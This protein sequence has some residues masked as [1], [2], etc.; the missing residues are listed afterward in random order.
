MQLVEDGTG[1][2][3]RAPK[4]LFG[5]IMH[6]EVGAQHATYRMAAERQNRINQNHLLLS[7]TLHTTLKSDL[8]IMSVEIGRTSKVRQLREEAVGH[9]EGLLTDKLEE[10][11]ILQEQLAL[12]SKHHVRDIQ[13]I[14]PY[15][16]VGNYT[17]PVHNDKMEG[18]GTMKYDDGRVYAG[19]YRGTV[20]ISYIQS[21]LH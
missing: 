7:H 2:V 1:T 5:S 14:D 16:D 11:A 10:V 21:T 3:D 8:I 17:G 19:E 4:Y 13:M 6:V 9:L 18:N 12:L 20:D 15:G